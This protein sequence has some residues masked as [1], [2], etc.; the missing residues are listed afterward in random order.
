MNDKGQKTNQTASA[1]ESIYDAYGPMLYGIALELAAGVNQA[2][3][4]LARTFA[5]I[6]KQNLFT[7]DQSSVCARLIRLLIESAQEVLD[8]R[9]TEN[10]KL[11][12]FEKTP[13]IHKLLCEQANITDYCEE[14]KL[15]RLEAGKKL[16]EELMSIRNQPAQIDR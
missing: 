1:I 11:K 8:T 14:S 4:I 6:R 5:K 16:R 3:E 7:E 9:Q 2:D 13:L 10:I 15:T 12:H